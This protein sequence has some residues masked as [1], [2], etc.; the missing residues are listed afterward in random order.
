VVDDLV[1][2]N[3]VFD[4]SQLITRGISNAKKSLRNMS[5]LGGY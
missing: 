2:Q 1:A 3:E 4:G 5:A